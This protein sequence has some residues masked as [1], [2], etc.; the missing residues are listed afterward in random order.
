[1][2]TRVDPEAENQ[3]GFQRPASPLPIR[4]SLKFLEKRV[5]IE[6]GSS[7]GTLAGHNHLWRPGLGW[8]RLLI[9][10]TDPIYASYNFD[11]LFTV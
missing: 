11:D 5:E 2:A 10:G 1:M 8:R 3:S 4:V 6:D 7:E 9:D